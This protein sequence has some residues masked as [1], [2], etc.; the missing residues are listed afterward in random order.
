MGR[1]NATGFTLRMKRELKEESDRLEASKPP[2]CK[3][4]SHEFSG[5]DNGERDEFCLRC[6]RWVRLF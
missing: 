3:K 2:K 5:R 6:Q 1:K 4:G